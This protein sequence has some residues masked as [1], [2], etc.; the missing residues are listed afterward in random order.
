MTR[1]LA[2]AIAMML[3]AYATAGGGSCPPPNEDL[4]CQDGTWFV[5]DKRVPAM[6]IKRAQKVEPLEVKAHA[7]NK[8]SMTAI[9]TYEDGTRAMCQYLMRWQQVVLK[10]RAG[11]QFLPESENCVPK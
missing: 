5:Q 4:T 8:V 7:D 9:L 2:F 1:L 3:S 10:D 6:Q 11:V